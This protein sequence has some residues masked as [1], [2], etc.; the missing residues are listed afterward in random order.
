[1]QRNS[2]TS[3]KEAV[4]TSATFKQLIE[5]LRGTKGS[6]DLFPH[7][8]VETT[9]TQKQSVQGGA[10]LS[11]LSNTVNGGG[12]SWVNTILSFITF[13]AVGGAFQRGSYMAAD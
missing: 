11:N 10:Q 4:G 7:R 2:F 13:S 9:L 6:H 12:R 5:T 8:P 1:M 3:T